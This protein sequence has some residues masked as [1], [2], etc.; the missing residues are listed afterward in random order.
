[1]TNLTT[2]I[3]RPHKGDI[4]QQYYGLTGYTDYQ[5]GTVAYT[6]YKGAIVMMDVSD[7]DG[8]AQPMLSSI[9]AASGD[10]FLGIAE[11]KVSVTSADT[12][13]GT[14]GVLCMTKGIVGFP[15]GS[16]AVTDIGAPIYATDDTT[17]QTTSSNALWI[18]TLVKVDDT[19][20]WVNI[21]HAAGRTNT[22]T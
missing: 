11:E 14:K 13:D 3:T 1:M 5:A 9:T 22:A 18:G 10:I 4:E 20:A 2:N 15:K 16:L 7:K 21:G 6:V 8:Y 12:A 19:Y 17:I